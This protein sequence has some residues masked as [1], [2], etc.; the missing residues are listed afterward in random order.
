MLF[1]SLVHRRQG[2]ERIVEGDEIV[3]RLVRHDQRVIKRHS[4]GPTTALLVTLRPRDVHEDAP[5]QPRGHREEVGPVLPVDVLDVDQ[6]EVGLVHQRRG[7]QAVP[8]ALA[9]QAAPRDPAQFI[10]YER[11]Q[12]VEGGLIAFP[13]CEEQSGDLVGI[14]G[15]EPILRFSLRVRASL[16]LCWE[17]DGDDFVGLCMT[18]AHEMREAAGDEGRIA[19]TGAGEDEKRS[20]DL[21]TASRCFILP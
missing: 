1:R 5:H 18:V 20:F 16:R 8:A 14:V 9:R 4:D 12:L 7:L 6:P 2:L 15:N 3:P 17:G 11:N 10:V 19:R 13:P 21:Q